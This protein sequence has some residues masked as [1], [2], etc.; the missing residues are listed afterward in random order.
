MNWIDVILILILFFS[1]VRSV[2]RG[3]L[4][5][6]ADLLCWAGSLLAGFF[7]YGPVSKFLGNYI[8][9][10]PW[11]VP[12]TFM[13]LLIAAAYYWKRPQEGSYLGSRKKHTRVS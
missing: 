6:A 3:F 5:T 11:L 1:V 8:S 2:Q 10:G 9:M 12:L 7:L 4:I 13:V